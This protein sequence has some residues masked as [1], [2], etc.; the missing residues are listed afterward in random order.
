MKLVP[1][2]K[3]VKLDSDATAPSGKGKL[4]N[5]VLILSDS[6]PYDADTIFDQAWRNNMSMYKR[7]ASLSGNRVTVTCLEDELQ[8]Q[9]DLLKDVLPQVVGIYNERIAMAEKRRQEAKDEAVATKERLSNLND[10]LKF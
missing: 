8:G 3:I 10:R 5:M 7:S 2:I 1:D 9:I 6:L 4:L